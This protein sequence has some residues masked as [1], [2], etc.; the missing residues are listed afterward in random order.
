[1]CNAGAM[2]E[3]LG[4]KSDMKLLASGSKVLSFRKL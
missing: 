2:F 3:D 4:L 1:M